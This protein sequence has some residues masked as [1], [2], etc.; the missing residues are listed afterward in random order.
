MFLTGNHDPDVSEQGWLD[1][2]GGAVFV[3]HGDMVHRGVAP[4]SREYMARKQE[5]AAV[6]AARADHPDELAARWAATRQVEEVLH[7]RMPRRLKLRG[8][9]QLLSA[10]W[11]PE[12][13]LAILWAWA[14]MFRAGLEFLRQY[15][16]AARVMI[17]GHFHRPGV[18]WRDGCLLVNTGA[19][20]NGSAVRAVDLDGR[21]LTV[22]RV[23]RDAERTFVP[24]EAMEVVRLG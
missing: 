23:I 11:P 21:Y 22:R 6:W 15:R 10:L 19:F 3:T 13:P 24:G 12:R 14:T 9:W 1:L 4:W 2:L 5:V 20:M 16:P 18:V 17:F 7:V 8:K